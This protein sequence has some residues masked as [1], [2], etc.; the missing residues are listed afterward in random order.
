MAA[1]NPMAAANPMEI[2]PVKIS[3]RAEWFRLR[4]LLWPK[5]IEE[6]EGEIAAFLDE[7]TPKS[8]VFVL[9]RG[10]GR[11]GGFVEASIRTY[12]EDC[13]SDEIAYVEGWYVELDLRQQGYGRQLVQQVE[14][15]G[16]SLGLTEMASDCLLDNTVSYRAHL[17][18]GFEE[19]DR[20]ICFRKDLT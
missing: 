10:D 17:A 12:A 6:H 5:A 4:C 2:R 13:A 19:V 8:A 3:D 7:S 9:D 20:I 15:W 1:G 11:L 16:R 18:L 14:T